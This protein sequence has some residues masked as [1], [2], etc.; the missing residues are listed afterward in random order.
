MVARVTRRIESRCVRRAVFAAGAAFA[1]HAA[2][3][4]AEAG[5]VVMRTGGCTHYVVALPSGR[6]VLLKWFGGYDPA[7]GDQVDGAFLAYGMTTVRTLSGGLQ[8]SAW[9]EDFMLSADGAARRMVER[10]A[11]RGG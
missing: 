11:L 4:C 2:P 7:P 1:L 9:V 10:C 5:T 3:A 8:G 6:F